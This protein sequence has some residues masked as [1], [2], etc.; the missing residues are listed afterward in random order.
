MFIVADERLLHEF[1]VEAAWH[2]QRKSVL[3]KV[4]ADRRKGC[5]ETVVGIAKKAEDRLC[6]KF[7]RMT[8]RG[9]LPQIAAV[10]VAR[11]LSGFAWAIAKHFPTTAA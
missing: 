9:K 7:S 10:A 2:Y 3:S 1:L 5:P 4:L 8:G 11:E 6:R